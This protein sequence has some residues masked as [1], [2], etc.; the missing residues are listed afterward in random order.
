M[1]RLGDSIGNV[2]EPL[3]GSHGR[4]QALP[5]IKGGPPPCHVI[6]PD[7]WCS[8]M[9]LALRSTWHPLTNHPNEPLGISGARSDKGSSQAEG[10]AQ[11]RPQP[12][13]YEEPG[14]PDPEEGNNQACSQAP[15]PCPLQQ[16][17]HG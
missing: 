16:P 8:A 7:L 1:V 6:A 3:A 9:A 10:Q 5:Y 15:L 17:T 12:G 14:K 13:E 2:G 4:G 11:V